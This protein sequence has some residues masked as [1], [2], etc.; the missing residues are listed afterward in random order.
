MEDMLVFFDHNDCVYIEIC[1]SIAKNKLMDRKE[2][3]ILF[4][5]LCLEG[6]EW[7]NIS[8]DSWFGD[9]FLISVEYSPRIGF[10]MTAIVRAGPVVDVHNSPLSQTRLKI[11]E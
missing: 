5:K 11:N 6:C 3:E 2:F 7:I 9:T 4:E 8:G 10:P 1:W